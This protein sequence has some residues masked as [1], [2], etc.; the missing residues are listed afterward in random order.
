MVEITD[1]T[2]QAIIIVKAAPRVGQTHGELVCC[3][4]IDR[5]GYWVR[6]YLVA[7]RTLEEAQKFKRWDQIEYKWS[8]PKGDHRSESRRVS[9]KSLSISGHIKA[10][11]AR[12]NLIAPLVVESL[13][14]E[15]EAGKSLAFIRPLQPRFKIE[16]KSKSQFEEEKNEF[17]RW[18]KQETESLFGFMSKN[19]VP[20][21]PSP[22][23]FKYVYEISDGTREG[24]CQD[25][26][27]EATFL[28]WRNTYGEARALEFMQTRF[29]EE[30][31]S[32]GFVLAMGTHKAYANWLINGIVRLDHGAEERIQ[33]SLF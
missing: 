7:F 23:S 22:Y 2:A 12:E 3:A 31:P 17:L 6:L 29:G 15:A 33:K 16:K 9:H 20:Y 4:G 5:E 26:E 8:L 27:V 13:A 18:H 32:R 30:Y 14:K 19:L 1:T 28:K 25:W 10:S 24:T 11:A 21:E